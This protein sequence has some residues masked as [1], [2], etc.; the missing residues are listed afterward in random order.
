MQSLYAI[1]LVTMFMREYVCV[2]LAY[3][4]YELLMLR[5]KKDKI[6][7]YKVTTAAREILGYQYNLAVIE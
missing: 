1:R 2:C 5:D 7:K 4:I 6:F 3:I